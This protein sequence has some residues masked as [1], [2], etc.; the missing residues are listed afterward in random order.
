MTSVRIQQRSNY[1]SLV[2]LAPE[3]YCLCNCYGSAVVT[4]CI[5][6]LIIILVLM[7]VMS[8]LPCLG[9]FDHVRHD[10]LVVQGTQIDVFSQHRHWGFTGSEHKLNYL[11]P[12][13]RSWFL[14]R[15][16]GVWLTSGEN[17]AQAAGVD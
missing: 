11:G 10:K 13:G 1:S 17:R 5:H 3:L 8:V 12:L 4:T 16:P 7:M 15:L 14:G 2:G 9:C 6:P